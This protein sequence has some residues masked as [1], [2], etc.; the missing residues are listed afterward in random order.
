MITPRLLTFG[1]ADGD[2]AVSISSFFALCDPGAAAAEDGTITYEM[3]YLGTRIEG[4][5]SI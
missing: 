2:S 1:D 3:G 4:L 5:Q